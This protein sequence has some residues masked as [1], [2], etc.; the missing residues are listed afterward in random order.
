MACTQGGPKAISVVKLMLSKDQIWKVRDKVSKPPSLYPTAGTSG[1]SEG[2]KLIF[3]NTS[4][5]EASQ[6]RC[7]DVLEQAGV[8]MGVPV[9]PHATLGR[10][11]SQMSTVSPDTFFRAVRMMRCTIPSLSCLFQVLS[12]TS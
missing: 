8:I 2:P 9:I 6:L 7:T 1:M 12:N 3:A 5:S 11:Q 10:G 4:Y